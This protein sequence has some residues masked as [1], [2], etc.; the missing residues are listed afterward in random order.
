MKE[1][2]PAGFKIAIKIPLPK[3]HNGKK[4]GFDDHRGISLLPAFDKI[5]QRIILN[6]MQSIPGTQIHSLQGLIKKNKM[7]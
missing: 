2:I 1:E 7:H 3:N 6:R 4:S 5:L